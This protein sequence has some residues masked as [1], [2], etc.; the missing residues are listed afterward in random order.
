MNMPDNF[1][2]HLLR[3]KMF[4]KTRLAPSRSGKNLP[5]E[6]IVPFKV[7]VLKRRYITRNGLLYVI[8]NWSNSIEC[9]WIS[10]ERY[11]QCIKGWNNSWESVLFSLGGGKSFTFSITIACDEQHLPWKPLL[12]HLRGSNWPNTCKISSLFLFTLKENDTL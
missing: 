12:V 9:K 1:S 8:E 3:G 7:S 5:Q 2:W 10:W 4:R 6:E 11:K